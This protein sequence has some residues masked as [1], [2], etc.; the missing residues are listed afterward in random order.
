[1][2]VK[3]A[4][5]VEN[6]RIWTSADVYTA[7]EGTTL[8][9]NIASA[10]NGAFDAVG[11]ISQDDAISLEWSSD[12][13]DHYAYGSVYIRKTS[14]KAKQTLNFTALEDSDIVFQ[15][16]Y[17][18]SDSATATGITTRTVRPKNLGLA[19]VAMVVELT[20]GDITKRIAIPRAQVTIAGSASLSDNEMAGVPMVVDMLGATDNNDETYFSIEI[21]DDP[22]AIA[23]S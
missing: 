9:T 21:T 12:D 6:V 14:I 15:L 2:E 8:P 7:P 20:D 11:Y 16:A 5:T 18:G 22:G 1:L 23:P 13:T 19:V 3:V 17:P 10:L 4:G